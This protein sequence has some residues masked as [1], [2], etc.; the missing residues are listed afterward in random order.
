ME[1]RQHS[2]R[3]SFVAKAGIDAAD[4]KAEEAKQETDTIEIQRRHHQQAMAQILAGTLTGI[5]SAINNLSQSVT[6]LSQKVFQMGSNA[7]IHAT[8]MQMQL[9][10][11][12]NRPKAIANDNRKLAA[13]L[14]GFTKKITLR[15]EVCT[16]FTSFNKLPIELRVKIWT[17]AVNQ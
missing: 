4:G 7:N 8:N 15:D 2:S 10:Q 9:S 14:K 5:F 17:L 11:L 1:S 3:L 13:G 6:T 12:R 16:T